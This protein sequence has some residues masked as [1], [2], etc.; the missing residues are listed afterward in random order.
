MGGFPYRGRNVIEW[1]RHSLHYA[2]DAWVLGW[3]MEAGEGGSG[4]LLHYEMMMQNGFFDPLFSKFSVYR[5]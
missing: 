1:T 2:M 4:I 5:S 3:V